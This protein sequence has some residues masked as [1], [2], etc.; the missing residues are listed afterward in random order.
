MIWLP[1]A[2]GGEGLQTRSRWCGA[3]RRRNSDD[4]DVMSQPPVGEMKALLAVPRVL[5]YEAGRGL[6]AHAQRGQ[7]RPTDSH[8][9]LA[10]W[11]DSQASPARVQRT[12][13]G[14]LQPGVGDRCTAPVRH[15]RSPCRV[16]GGRPPS[17]RPS[18]RPCTSQLSGA[19]PG[20]ARSRRP[21][22][23][24]RRH[25]HHDLELAADHGGVVLGADALLQ[26]DQ[27]YAGSARRDVSGDL[28]WSRWRRA[29]RAS[30]GTNAGATRLSMTSSVWPS[31]LVSGSRR[32]I[33]VMASGI[34]AHVRQDPP[35]SR[36]RAAHLAQHRVRSDCSAC[37]GEGI[38]VDISAIASASCVGGRVGTW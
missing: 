7:A 27:A 33:R 13:N 22:G 1:P 19:R 35:S 25:G 2:A 38:T 20:C 23:G 21:W 24:R 18:T 8:G 15:A 30:T 6:S 34:D 36:R 31:G 9:L 12:R 5:I 26:G 17:G 37:A 10:S 32:G 11:Q 14:R 3:G 4:A 16:A 29:R 28:V